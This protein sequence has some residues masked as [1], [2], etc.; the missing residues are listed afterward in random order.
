MFPNRILI[1]WLVG[2]CVLSVC[3]CVCVCVCGC[4][5][6]EC[7]DSGAD[8][9]QKKGGKNGNRGNREI[10]EAECILW[11]FT[12]KRLQSTGVITSTVGFFKA[13]FLDGFCWG[14]ALKYSHEGG[15][16]HKWPW[17]QNQ[18]G[19][20]SH[21]SFFFSLFFF[22]PPQSSLFVA[23][24][25]PLLAAAQSYKSKPGPGSAYVQIPPPPPHYPKKR[26]YAKH[27]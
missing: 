1:G 18:N 12:L 23:Q 5:G 26:P 14:K 7:L 15:H 22:S 27:L 20:H 13:V 17:F 25:Q 8:P 16:N 24:I 2:A 11:S 3:V 6:G 19:A 10:D 4:S 21:F 9:H